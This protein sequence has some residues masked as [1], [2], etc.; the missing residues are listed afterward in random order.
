MGRVAVG[1]GR[2]WP[3]SAAPAAAVALALTVA[4]VAAGCGGGSPRTYD[5]GRSLPSLLGGGFAAERAP[6]MPDTL[7][8]VRQVDY[9]QTTAPDG[10]RIDL[11]FLETPAAAA[12]EHDAAAARTR[13]FHG[14]VAGNVLVLP[15]PATTAVPGDDMSYLKSLL[16]T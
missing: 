15:V 7:A 2:R 6:G 5:A 3:A 16:R 9:L 8:G 10:R 11:Q 13:G 1:P 4:L 12:R 14:A